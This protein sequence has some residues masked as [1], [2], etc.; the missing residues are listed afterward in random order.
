MDQIMD[1]GSDNG[2]DKKHGSDKNRKCKMLLCVT[3]LNIWIL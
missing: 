1:N 2:S 3:G